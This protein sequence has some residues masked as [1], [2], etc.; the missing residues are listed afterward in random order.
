MA[1]FRRFFTVSQATISRN[2]TLDN[3]TP[4]VSY[5]FTGVRRARAGIDR[6]ATTGFVIARTTRR[7]RQ[8][9]ASCVRISEEELSTL[10]M[11]G[12][13]GVGRVR[14]TVDA[15]LRNRVIADE[16]PVAIA[17]REHASKVAP[18]LVGRLCAWPSEL[19]ES[20]LTRLDE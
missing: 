4:H 20:N 15:G 1:K 16:D 5:G 9:V 3:E 13:S 6:S 10:L 7:T 17:C 11:V 14:G 2:P 8:G 19:C 12:R 18:D